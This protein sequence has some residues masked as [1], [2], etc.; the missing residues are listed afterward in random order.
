MGQIK[1]FLSPVQNWY[2]EIK[3]A[4]CVESLCCSHIPLWVLKN[5]GLNMN[6]AVFLS[7]GFKLSGEDNTNYTVHM[8]KYF[9]ASFRGR[10]KRV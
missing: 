9:S 3:M 8:Y 10:N 6:W 7:V 1:M 5:L 2:S 4:W